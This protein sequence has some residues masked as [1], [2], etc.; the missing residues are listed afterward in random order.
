MISRDQISAEMW[1]L[2]LPATRR[3]TQWVV[4]VAVCQIAALL[5]LRRSPAYGLAR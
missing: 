2:R 4:G 3:Q 5:F 1:L